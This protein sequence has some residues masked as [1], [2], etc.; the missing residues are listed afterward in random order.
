MKKVVI[1][2]NLKIEELKKASESDYKQ[3]KCY[4]DKNKR[5][6]NEN[7]ELRMSSLESVE[8]VKVQD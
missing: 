4:E 7:E 2:Y 1:E 8:L 3:H 6:A 5:L